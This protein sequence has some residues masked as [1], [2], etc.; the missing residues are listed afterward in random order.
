MTYYIYCA[1]IENLKILQQHFRNYNPLFKVE[2]ISDILRLSSTIPSKSGS[3]IILDLTENE[4]PLDCYQFVFNKFHNVAIISNQPNHA[5][6]AYEYGAFDF[7][8]S[9]YTSIRLNS[10]LSKLKNRDISNY[11]KSENETILVKNG[12][13]LLKLEIKEIVY[14]KA[15][16]NYIRI[17]FANNKVITSLEKISFI[18]HRLPAEIFLRIHKSFIINSKYLNSYNNK[19]VVLN[20]GITLPL[21]LTYKHHFRGNSNFT[22]I[23]INH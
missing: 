7:I 14:I 8:L 12:R 19:E 5:V 9:P 2:P 4:L 23:K 15:M 3:V 18:Q 16:G 22:R 20:N 21:S 10:T 11:N 17:H 1:E 6:L 13:D